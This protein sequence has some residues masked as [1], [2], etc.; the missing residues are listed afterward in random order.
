MSATGI[1]IHLLAGD[2]NFVRGAGR[3]FVRGITNPLESSG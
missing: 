3:C 2:G 1:S